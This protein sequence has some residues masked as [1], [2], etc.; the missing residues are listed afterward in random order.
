MRTFKFNIGDMIKPFSPQLSLITPAN[1]QK[2][3]REHLRV[4]FRFWDGKDNIYVVEAD[5]GVSL[6]IMEKDAVLDDRL[7]TATPRTYTINVKYRIGDKV[8]IMF[9]D[10]PVCLKI[11]KIRIN[12][13][14]EDVNGS[15]SDFGKVRY[16]LS[17]DNC[18]EFSEQQLCDTFEELRDRI[19]SNAM[20]ESAEQAIMEEK[21]EQS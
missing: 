15:T 18:K 17:H 13:G 11:T 9:D 10:F 14:S 4:T 21:E 19:F 12:G 7:K 6:F 3:Y 5:D 2:E 20:R 16:C 1:P 8:W